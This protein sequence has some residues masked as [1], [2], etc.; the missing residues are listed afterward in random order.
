MG[1]AD[2]HRIMSHIPQQ[3]SG[4]LIIGTQTFDDAAVYEIEPGMALVQTVD[5]FT[6]IV[7]DPYE[8]GAIAAAN[9]LSDIYAMGARPIIALNIACFPRSLGTDLLGEIV[10]GGAFKVNE[11]GAIVAGGHTVE[12]DD[13]KF[14]LSVTG[15]VRPDQITANSNGRAG[16][17]LYLTK[18]LGTGVISTALKNGRCPEGAEEAARLSMLSLNDRGARAM[19]KA[20]ARAATDVTG[21]GFLGHLYELASGSGLTAEVWANELPLLDGA[22]ELAAE[23]YLPGG[24]ARNRAFLAP[25]VSISG[26]IPEEVQGLM[27]DPQTSGG[28]LIAIP[29]DK[30][31]VLERELTAEGCNFWAVG[32]L[33]DKVGASVIALTRK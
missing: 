31:D 26:E 10:R 1:P 22:R 23:G 4:R 19:V 28:L 32:R 29:Q 7:D 3:S 33:Y 15:I 12:D 2:L 5:F 16:D 25:H 17:L 24:A 18:P 9:A 13:L 8:F 27:F 20:G 21:F 11:A 6:P 14:G 30:A